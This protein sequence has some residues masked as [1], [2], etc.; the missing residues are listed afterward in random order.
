[1]ERVSYIQ[2][3]YTESC[4]IYILVFG[5]TKHTEGF[6]NILKMSKWLYMVKQDISVSGHQWYVV[7]F[8][9]LLC[10]LAL[11]PILSSFFSPAAAPLL[12]IPSHSPIFSLPCAP[13]IAC[14]PAI[15]PPPAVRICSRERYI[16]E[17]KVGVELPF[18]ASYCKSKRLND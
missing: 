1:M 9:S 2:F 7:A 18:L 3:I 4:T 10:H 8:L 12:P 13:R 5:D 15:K 17:T 16:G 6:K 14:P 11:A